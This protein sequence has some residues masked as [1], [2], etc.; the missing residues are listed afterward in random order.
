MKQVSGKPCGAMFAAIVLMSLPAIFLAPEAAAEEELANRMQGDLGAAAYGNHSPIRGDA[1]RALLAPYGFFDYGRFFARIDTVGIK[2]VPLGYGYLEIA[3][4]IKFDGYQTNTAALRGISERKNSVPLGIGSFQVT[5]IGGFFL[6]AFFDVN[7][8]RGS[9]Y[10][11][12]Y[13]AEIEVGRGAIYPEAGFEHYSGNYTRYYYGVSTTE[14]AARGYR[15]Y[16]PSAATTPLLGLMLEIP[17]RGNWYTGLFLRR[18]WLGA[19]ISNS[20]LVD[21]NHQDTAFLSLN[22]RYK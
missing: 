16:A 3:G 21:S 19:A 14:A 12:I 11:V 8:S 4:R 1:N 18:R 6:N 7:V 10:E 5:P 13:A 15:T 17:V 20:P 9:M 22:Y 2:T